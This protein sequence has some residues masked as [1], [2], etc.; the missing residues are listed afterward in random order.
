MPSKTFNSEQGERT[1]NSENPQDSNNGKKVKGSSQK[2]WFSKA[3]FLQTWNTF[4]PIPLGYFILTFMALPMNIFLW[5]IDL[6]LQMNVYRDIAEYGNMGQRY[7]LVCAVMLGIL[8]AML[9]FR[10]LTNH[11]SANMIHALPVR[12]E[13]LYMT[14]YLAGLSFILVPNVV[15]LAL[16]WVAC[17][18]QGITFFEPFLYLFFVSSGLYFFFYSFGVFCAMLT[19]SVG[20]ISIYYLVLNSIVAFV[21]L[22]IQPLFEAYYVGYVGNTFSYP[23]VQL[24]T[25]VYAMAY[26]SKVTI[27]YQY[28]TKVAHDIGGYYYPQP[29]NISFA[30]NDW[31]TYAIYMVMGFV[32]I[33]LGLLFYKARHIEVAGEA[34]SMEWLKPVFRFVWSVVGGS[35]LGIITVVMVLDT[36]TGSLAMNWFPVASLVWGILFAFVAEMIIEKSFRVL[37]RWKKMVAP[38]LAVVLF[39]SVLYFDL[40]GFETAIPNYKE[41]EGVT[42]GTGNLYPYDSASSLEQLD[43]SKEDIF[44]DLSAMHLR[45]VDL[46]KTYNL[47][48]ENSEA[49]QLGG[50]V[51]YGIF[52]DFTFLNLTYHLEDGYNIARSYYLGYHLDDSAQEDSFAS[53]FLKLVNDRD[54][55]RGVY[56]LDEMQGSLSNLMFTALY[57]P[58]RDEISP[59]VNMDYLNPNLTVMEKEEVFLLLG[60]ALL[61]DFEEGAL[62]V[63]YLHPSDETY[64][65]DV[66]Y[67]KILV[68]WTRN[69][70]ESTLSNMSYA[71]ES[72]DDSVEEGAGSTS[73]KTLGSD[74]EKREVQTIF[75]INKQCVHTLAVLEKYELLGEYEMISSM[76]ML[77][78]CVRWYGEGTEE[79][80][81]KIPEI[82]PVA[83]E[84]EYQDPLTFVWNVS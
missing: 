74:E 56:H 30:M 80:L 13:A 71:S 72:A 38:S 5:E 79:S 39:Y 58:E 34:I 16:T 54:R 4:M 59:A 24:L 73:A 23:F 69:D 43:V 48:S 12:R 53:L 37:K 50:A 14:Q 18:F 40:T 81:S 28:S 35:S 22:L 31:E 32:F 64:L 77:E 62:G 9:V 67:G 83:S 17:M 2:S 36:A 76:E 20:A 19:G 57:V 52:D 15:I 66:Y 75:S 63:K 1:L 42:I 8:S 82:P 61:Q 33:G 44:S 68:N 84:L 60:Q 46:T 10:Y 45:A 25:P 11:R 49:L 47:L 41:V 6:E 3:L 27:N 7:G 65:E 70:D 26:G 55:Q 29:E 21:T 78:N 51:A